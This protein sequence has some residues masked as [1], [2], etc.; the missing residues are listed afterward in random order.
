VFAC[1]LAGAA[2]LAC[3]SAAAANPTARDARPA[4][5]VSSLTP[6]A[7]DAQWRGLVERGRV[8]RVSAAD[9]CLSLRA[10]FYA[11]TDWL[12]LATKLAANA[13]PCAQYF[14][15]VPPAVADKIQLRPDQAWRIR[16]LGPAFHALAEIN[17]NGWTSWVA[18]TGAGWY[19]AGV[20]ARRRMAAAGYD[21]AAGD[22]W[23]LNELSAAVRQGAG[24]ARANIRAF[25]NGLHDGAPGMPPARGA[26]FVTGVDQGAQELSVYQARLQDW[27]EDEAFWTDMNRF[28]SDW[29]QELYGSVRTYAVAGAT[30]AAR[31]DALNEYL[32]HQLSLAAAA[33]PSAAAARRFLEAASNPLA[34]AAW[35]YGAAYGWTDVPLDVM[36]DYV[37]AQTFAARSAGNSRFGF[38]WAPRNATG[39]PAEEFAAQTDALL[40][41][42][43]AAIADSGVA[44]AAACGADWCTRS[45]PG[46]A[47]TTGWRAFSQWRPSRVAIATPPPTVDAGA[48][49][50]PVTVELRTN[51]GLPYAAGLPL[52]VSV[53]SSSPTAAFATSPD[54]PWT[55]TLAASIA[56]GARTTRVYFRDTRPGSATIVARAAGRIGAAQIAT[57]TAPL[58]AAPATP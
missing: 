47:F 56:A 3:A 38:A 42:L 21:V 37:S 36:Q 33:P 28:A 41:R 46:A 18:T 9:D 13:S 11:S 5:P 40:E 19:A 49:S 29:S 34:N 2:V 35:Q 16:A 32:Q 30:P 26:V 10:V 44:A 58:G 22:S 54:G 12:R 17:V 48:P 43:A 55:A 53:S 24:S 31:R 25:V 27:Y 4:R 23:A 14:V 50:L 6:T 7:T 57:V 1:T 52:A 39:L 45:L 15:S 20:E 51:T 8:R